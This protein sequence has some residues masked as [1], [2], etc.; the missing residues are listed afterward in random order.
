MKRFF[1]LSV[2]L[3]FVLVA[4]GNTNYDFKYTYEGTE[5]NYLKLTNNT[6]KVQYRDNTA[7][8]S[9]SASYPCLYTGDVI[10]PSTV[11]SDGVT[12]T[13][14]EISEYAF[15]YSSVASVV[16]PNTITRIGSSAFANCSSLENVSLPNGLKSIDMYAF[17]STTNLKSIELPNSNTV[18]GTGVFK[19]SGL[20]SIK[21]PSTCTSISRSMFSGCKS[22]ETVIIPN[23]VNTIADG[24]FYECDKIESI[25]I[26]K[27]VTSIGSNAFA[28]CQNLKNVNVS[29][30]TSSSIPA[31]VSATDFPFSTCTLWV[32]TGTKDLYLAKTY[33]KTFKSIEAGVKVAIEN[34]DGSDGSIVIDDNTSMT[35]NDGI[36]GIYIPRMVENMNVTYSRVYKT[37]SWAPWYMPFDLVLTDALLLNFEFAKYSGAYT[38]EY[39]ANDF[40]LRITRLHSGDVVKGNT[41]YFIKAKTADEVNPQTI[42]ASN[43]DLLTTDENSIYA[44]SMEKKLNI[45][46]LYS[47]KTATADDMNWYYYSTNGE[48]CLPNV[49]TKI[50][51]LRFYLTIEDREDNPYGSSASPAKISIIEDETDGIETISS[52]DD[53]NAKGEMF[54]LRGQKIIN[55]QKGE[56]YIMNGKKFINQ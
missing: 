33:W 51:A 17:Q 30:N 40:V 7:S 6:C 2:L 3:V 48:Y 18:F 53:V 35:L 31:L 25:T 23:S 43:V 26:P 46:G 41:P 37:T 42:T 9:P 39:D 54:N 45:F 24:A 8:S 1:I 15:Q 47:A 13:V 34:K 56:I 5:L 55:P 28:E 19:G 52:N 21:I 4:R 16:L 44:L 20:K 32:P 38:D 14:T 49:G 12:Y 29:W 27:S 10:V 11:V 50:G 36:N 22:M